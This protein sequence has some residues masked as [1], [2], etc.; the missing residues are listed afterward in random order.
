MPSALH[1]RVAAFLR[2]P[3]AILSLAVFC[4]V[5]AVAPPTVAATFTVDSTGGAGD[6]SIGDGSCNDGSG[7]CTLLAAIQEANNY[8]VGA[9]HTIAFSVGS[10]QLTYELPQITVNGTV[11]DGWSHPSHVSGGPPV[12]ALSGES[13]LNSIG[14]RI[15]GSNITVRGLQ[16]YSF[17]RTG[18][19]VE[20]GT[21]G[22]TIQGCYIGTNGTTDLGNGEYGIY[23]DTSSSNTIGGTGAGEGNVIS[24]NQ[25][26]GIAINGS[27]GTASANTII[28]NLIGLNAAGASAMG[29]DGDGVTITNADAN[30]IGGGTAAA[31]NVISGNSGAGIMVVSGAAANSIY[32]NYVGTD[33][34]GSSAIP[35]G[36][37]VTILQDAT[38]TTIGGS[39]PGQGNVISGNTGTGITISS[40]SWSGA[41]LGNLIGVAVD[42]VSALGNGSHGIEIQATPDVLIGGSFSPGEP[43]VIAFNGGD[44]ISIFNPPCIL[45]HISANSIHD[46]A[47]LGIDLGNDG[48][49]ANDLGDADTGPN[50]L[51]N[52]PVLTSVT[53]GTGQTEISGT[54]NST[55]NRYFRLEFFASPL[56]DPTGF[57]EGAVYLGYLDSVLT[58]ASG[59]ASFTTALSGNVLPGWAI[60]ATA[61]D[62]S[63]NTSEFSA[64]ALLAAS[65]EPIPLL[66]SLGLAALIGLLAAAA[67]VALKGRTS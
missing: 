60:T 57:G 46:N 51:Q 44:G 22:A 2:R 18:I 32:G 29:N 42:G 30:T 21:T 56:C 47:G 58:D 64:C 48:V 9:P 33:A 41:V 43:N 17:Q 7:N 49:T 62:D 1:R 39:N 45:K 19:V 23:A 8:A 52:F 27:G 35:N 20:T 16:I 14:I 10:F 61:I 67:F 54:L 3:A 24:G 15:G 5:V 6:A 26:S 59:N 40:N 37:G 28:G 31:R 11:I 66:S 55:A 38:N 65:T 4:V 50:N 53:S 25:Q 34:A 36:S 12:V 13:A 63:G